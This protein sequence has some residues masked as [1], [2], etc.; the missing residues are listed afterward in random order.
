MN[1][2]S[3]KYLLTR[4]SSH[5]SPKY[6]PYIS[7]F[8]NRCS[9]FNNC[10]LCN[11]QIIKDGNILNNACVDHYHEDVNNRG[12]IRGLICN[13]CNVIEGKI[14]KMVDEGKTYKQLCEKYDCE[15]ISKI[16][17]WYQQGGGVLPMDTG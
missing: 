11:T 6:I 10:P 14:K 13:S 12:P 8:V 4:I 16:E 17:K 2:K 1:D 15:F 7:D 9:S 3:K 5:I